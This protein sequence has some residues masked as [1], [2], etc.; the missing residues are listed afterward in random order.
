MIQSV[1]FH[2]KILETLLLPWCWSQQKLQKR[3]WNLLWNLN[4]IENICHSFELCEP[5]TKNTYSQTQILTTRFD[6]N[7]INLRGPE[8]DN[9][10]HFLYTLDL[11]VMKLIVE[12]RIYLLALPLI[13]HIYVW[14]PQ[15]L[16]FLFHTW[17]F[18][19]VSL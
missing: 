19:L 6:L 7:V 14:V 17:L 2:Y 8:F 11:T 16:P 13:E 4:G 9:M 10:I 3:Q 12:F 18:F 1:L 15:K 5:S